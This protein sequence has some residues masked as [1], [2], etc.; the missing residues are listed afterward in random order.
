MELY[1]FFY[2]FYI[3]LYIYIP[4][5]LST[6]YSIINV[7]K[8]S[9]RLE[10]KKTTKKQT[11]IHINNVF[12]FVLEWEGECP[13]FKL[14]DLKNNLVYNMIYTLYYIVFLIRSINK[15]QKNNFIFFLGKPVYTSTCF[16]LVKLPVLTLLISIILLILC[17][18]AK[19]N[20][21]NLC[22]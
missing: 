8:V 5:C 12:K 4:F 21:V 7:H 11:K 20:R 22:F 16:S 10:N 13:E 6:A 15:N 19:Y 14:I 1:H 3:T 2:T 9:G 17:S 18:R